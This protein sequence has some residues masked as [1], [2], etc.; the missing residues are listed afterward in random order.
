MKRK[1][2]EEEQKKKEAEAV[3]ITATKKRQETA[4]AIALARQQELE[5]KKRRAEEQA[6]RSKD[7]KKKTKDILQ[8]VKGFADSAKESAKVATAASNG[9]IKRGKKRA[10]SEVDE[11]TEDRSDNLAFMKELP[12]VLANATATAISSSV[13]ACTTIVTG[14]LEEVMK[15]NSE[16]MSIIKDM[17]NNNHL[18]AMETQHTM[19]KQSLY[20]SEAAN[21]R[22]EADY[23]K[24]RH[25]DLEKRLVDA[26]KASDSIRASTYEEAKKW[27]EMFK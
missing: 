7:E 24:K 27:R 6:Q 11:D 3:A 21:R 18:L 17:A 15:A 13:Q 12:N 23:M 20:Y 26:E 8:Q 9:T 5:D 16:S 1:A 4:A 10:V 2:V 14:K 22:F 25:D 19:Q